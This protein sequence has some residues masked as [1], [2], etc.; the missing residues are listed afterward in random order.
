MNAEALQEKSGTR[1]DV[2]QSR[3]THTCLMGLRTKTI[4]L[5]IILVSPEAL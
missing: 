3:I 5:K 4:D 1:P 2:Q